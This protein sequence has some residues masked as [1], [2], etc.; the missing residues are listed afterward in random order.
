MERF[1]WWVYAY[2]LMNNHY[3]LLVETPEPNISSGM[4]QLNGVYTQRFNRN[5]IR[6]GHIFQGR[7]KSILVEK[8]SYLLELVRYVV[9]N[10][11]RA[12]TGIDFQTYAWSSYGA[13]A[14]LRPAPTWLRA[15]LV[16]SRFGTTTGSAQRRYIAFVNAGL[17]L[18]TVWDDLKQQIYLGSN[19]F[20]VQAQKRVPNAPHL[21]EVPL[22][23]RRSPAKALDD[24]SKDNK[25]AS[26]A[27]AAAY[28]SGHYSLAAIGRHFGVH[29]STVSRAVRVMEQKS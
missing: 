11:A 23:H 5:H 20:V 24:Y 10:P 15:D 6:T 29:Y 4:R 19:Q 9:L 21:S 2:C 8:D 22:A 27:M 28:R 13:T 7:Y 14:G 25:D 16:L 26:A 17:G 1:H 12:N 3:H 18:P